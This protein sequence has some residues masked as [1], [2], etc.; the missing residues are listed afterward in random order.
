MPIL[1]LALL[2]VPPKVTGEGARTDE[3]PRQMNADVL[4][5]FFDLVLAQFQKVVQEETVMDYADGNRRLCFH[6]LSTWIADH[7]EHVALDGIG[8]KLC[9]KCEVSNKDLGGNRLKMYET[10]TYILYRE[11]ALRH[12]PAEMAGIAE[13]S[14]QVGVKKE[15]MYPLNSTKETP[16][17]YISRTSYTTFTLAYSNI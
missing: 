16:P 5:T 8:S 1:L 11:E 17:T 13:Y 9:P 10:H 12:E 15:I 7:A 4:R 14:E 3:A 2:L 6:I